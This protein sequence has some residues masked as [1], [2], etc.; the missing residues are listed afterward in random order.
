MGTMSRAVH[1]ESTFGVRSQ[2][3]TRS[4]EHHDLHILFECDRPL[5]GSTRHCLDD[6]DEVLFTRGAERS[7]RREAL[8]NVRR[9]TLT[10][11][12]GRVASPHARLRRVEAAWAFEDGISSGE[13]VAKG[14]PPLAAGPTF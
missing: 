9:L 4:L 2:G 8:G 1:L 6:I 3:P 12:D 11:P 7:F 13:A 5:A 14:N 10:V